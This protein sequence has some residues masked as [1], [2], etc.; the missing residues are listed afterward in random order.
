MDLAQDKGLV[1]FEHGNQFSSSIQC[2]EILEQL[3]D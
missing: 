1:D 2:R 3:T